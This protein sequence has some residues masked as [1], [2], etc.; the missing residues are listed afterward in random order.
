MSLKPWPIT[1]MQTELF[2]LLGRWTDTI[3]CSC[4]QVDS[5]SLKD[6]MCLMQL[7]ANCSFNLLL[8]LVCGCKL[9]QS[10]FKG[11]MCSC[12]AALQN[13]VLLLQVSVSP[14][15][16]ITP[17]NITWCEQAFVQDWFL[18][19]VSYCNWSE[20]LKTMGFW[21]QSHNTQYKT[22]IV[23]FGWLVAVSITH[24]YSFLQNHLHAHIIKSRRRSYDDANNKQVEEKEKNQNNG[25]ICNLWFLKSHWSCSHS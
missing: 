25:F 18:T 22:G 7:F 21:F 4:I 17:C 24:T 2:H 8:S 23:K 13:C 6:V 12:Q 5:N 19:A 1:E 3:C 20:N 11:V 16:C 14:D 9:S 15:S 10:F